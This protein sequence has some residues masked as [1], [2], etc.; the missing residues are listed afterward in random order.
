[1]HTHIHIHYF[2]KTGSKQQQQKTK[3]RENP[4]KIVN[5]NCNKFSIDIS[6]NSNKINSPHKSIGN[7]HKKYIIRE[8]K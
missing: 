4:R 8:V 5:S 2:Y 7:T 6:L 1:M 3:M